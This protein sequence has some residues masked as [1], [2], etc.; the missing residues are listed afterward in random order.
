MGSSNRRP[1]LASRGSAMPAAGTYSLIRRQFLQIDFI[2]SEMFWFSYSFFGHL[3]SGERREQHQSLRERPRRRRR[4]HR[5]LCD[6]ERGQR[7][8]Q[9]GFEKQA[10]EAEQRHKRRGEKGRVCA[11]EVHGRGGGR[12][13]WNGEPREEPEQ[14]WSM[15]QGGAGSGGDRVNRERC[16]RLTTSP[17]VTRTTSR[18]VTRS[19]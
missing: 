3:Q 9:P 2:F 15:D 11:V 8:R 10:A 19:F 6:L 13:A 14:V 12:G 4:P 5:V 18:T 16:M 7:G 1:P 17:S